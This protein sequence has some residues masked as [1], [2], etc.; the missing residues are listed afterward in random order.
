MARNV[1][2]PTQVRTGRVKGYENWFFSPF[3]IAGDS[4][5]LAESRILHNDSVTLNILY[6]SEYE[7]L[8]NGSMMQLTGFIFPRPQ[9]TVLR[10]RFPARRRSHESYD[11]V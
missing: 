11:V 10:L 6:P 5:T 3:F 2:N 4:M 7:V 1:E 9:L 8:C